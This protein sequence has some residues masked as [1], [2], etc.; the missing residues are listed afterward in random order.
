MI[1]PGDVVFEYGG[2]HGCT[3]IVLSKWVGANGKVVPFEALPANCDIIEKN[4]QL[5]NLQNIYLERKAVGAK[6]GKITIENSSDS[7]VS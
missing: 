4:I 3:A 2:H 1:Q 7:S 6:H 5:N